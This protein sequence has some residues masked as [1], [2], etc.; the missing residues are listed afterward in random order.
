MRW[1]SVA[2]AV[3]ALV[4]IGCA[5]AV[6]VLLRPRPQMVEPPKPALLDNSV[7]AAAKG[8]K[9]KRVDPSGRETFSFSAAETLAMADGRTLFKGVRFKF[10]KGT[11][12]YIVTSNEAESEGK[13][14]PTGEEPSKMLFRKKVKMEGDDGFS[15][16]A[17][18]AT[19]L[20]DEQRV[21]FPGAVGFTRD[22]L[23]GRGVGADLYMDR[24]VLWLNDQSQM[25]IEPDKGGVPVEI[26]GKRVGLAQADGYI[27]AEEGTRLTRE[28]QQL[29]ADQMVVHFAEGT[30]SVRR[31]E[32]VGKSSALGT[33]KGQRPD[34]RGDNIDL[35]FTAE[36]GLLTHARM[37]TAAALTLRDD[38]GVTAVKSN[39]IDFHVGANGETLTKLEATGATE[40]ILPRVGEAPARTIHSNGLVAEGQDPKGLDRAVFS[41]GIQYR[42]MLPAGRGEAAAVRLATSQSLVLSL[43][44]GLNQVKDANFRQAFCF[45][46]P[47]APAAPALDPKCSTTKTLP[48]RGTSDDSMAAAADEGTYDAKAE[49][50][51]LKSTAPTR[52]RPWVVNREV[53]VEAREIDMDIKHNA[54]DA[55]GSAKEQV[56]FNRKPTPG[57][58]KASGTPGLFESDKAITVKTNTLKYSR[59]TGRA[60]YTGN[61]FMFQ[62]ASAGQAE[63]SVL[64][65]DEVNV[66]DEKHNIDATGNVRST[67]FIEQAPDEPGKKGPTRTT[68]NSNRMTYVEATRTALYAGAAVMET[69]EGATK[70]SLEAAEITLVMQT[71]K[72]ALKSLLSTAPGAGVVLAKLPEGRQSQGL[73]L[74]YDAE[75]DTYVMTGNPA[76]FVA[77]STTNAPGMCQ[78]GRG[79]RIEFPRTGGE[80]KVTAEGGGVGRLDEQRCA[81]VIK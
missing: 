17:E 40:T 75:K 27:R 3:V 57:Q 33:G 11:V 23:R 22:R 50:L 72:R 73:R 48:A 74:T 9:Q 70:Q 21:A 52:P 54:I 24:S 34:M 51:R 47:L 56:D 4:G 2:R 7:T 65:A 45:V 79:S 46:G 81:E 39:A 26:S 25:T 55:R 80:A 49:T 77:P 38:S 44:G 14:G 32:L 68:L 60:T 1:Q 69:G 28:S 16:E 58:T 61:V 63:G 8:T 42:E 15:V 18:D 13:S 12:T 20:G 66:D 31:I 76:Q 6:Y 37:D 62:P 67:L 78:V 5:V 59:D 41:G 36:S 53:T 71:E 64:K 19:Y 10:T 35:D 30:Q 43:D 29:R